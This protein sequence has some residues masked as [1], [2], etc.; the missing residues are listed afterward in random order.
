MRKRV[1][2]RK[3]SRDRGSRKALFRSLIKALCEHGAIVT[4]KAKAKSIQATLDKLVS[5]AQ[6]ESLAGKRKV[7]SF[8]GNDRKTADRIFKLAKSNFQ[9]RAGGYTRTVNLPLRRGD[10]AKVVRLEWVEEI[11]ISNKQNLRLRQKGVN[12]KSKK[13]SKK[14]SKKVVRKTKK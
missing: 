12:D 8:L 6:K 4:T 7:L 5:V 1:F 11:G 2:G 14:E 3:L 10:A 13:K 9:K